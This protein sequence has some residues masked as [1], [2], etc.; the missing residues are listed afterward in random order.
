MARKLARGKVAPEL[1]RR[2]RA[3][4]LLLVSHR[5]GLVCTQLYVLRLPARA[6]GR[7]RVIG[8][9]MGD[10]GAA[11]RQ[12]PG[13]AWRLPAAHHTRVQRVCASLNTHHSP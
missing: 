9:R 7:L 8:P 13:G 1:L 3:A 2:L 4:V 6:R 11:R 5:A 10:G 12:L